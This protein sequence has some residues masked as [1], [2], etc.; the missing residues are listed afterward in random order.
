MFE[1]KTI[2]ESIFVNYLAE[3]QRKKISASIGHKV[4]MLSLTFLTKMI[5]LTKILNIKL[6]LRGQIIF[7]TISHI[8]NNTV[9]IY[10][11]TILNFKN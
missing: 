6:T 4:K 3:K 9:I 2:F 7:E 10:G 11:A 8:L 5:Q 1:K